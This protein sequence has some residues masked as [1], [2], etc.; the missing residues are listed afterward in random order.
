MTAKPQFPNENP[1]TIADLLGTSSEDLLR[2]MQAAQQ[3]DSRK[4]KAVDLDM[5]VASFPVQ[6]D[7]AEGMEPQDLP[8][9]RSVVRFLTSSPLFLELL[10]LLGLVMTI[11]AKKVEKCGLFIFLTGEDGKKYSFSGKEDVFSGPDGDVIGLIEI[12][13]PDGTRTYVFG[14]RVDEGNGR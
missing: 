9:R 11:R 1:I 2:A 4:G 3:I 6:D 12:I 14:T 7:P 5:F 10:R 8:L 13:G